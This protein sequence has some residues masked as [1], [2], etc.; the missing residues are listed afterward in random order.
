LKIIAENTTYYFAKNTTYLK[1]IA[2]NT[3]Y[4]F[5]EKNLGKGPWRPG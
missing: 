3:T 4:Y 1:I 5:A 2:E